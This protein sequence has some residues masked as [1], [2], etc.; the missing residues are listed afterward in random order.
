[1]C[2]EVPLV[3]LG[4][5]FTIAAYAV[6]RAAR[7][8][9]TELIAWLGGQESASG[10]NVWR[11]SNGGATFPPTD[12]PMVDYSNWASG[13]TTSTAAQRCAAI[14]AIHGKWL[15]MDC[16][17]H[18]IYLV[19][20]QIAP[21]PVPPPSPP[22]TPPAVVALVVAGAQELSGTLLVVLVLSIGGPLS[23]M[24]VL[25]VRRLVRRRRAALTEAGAGGEIQ[26]GDESQGVVG[27]SV[28]RDSSGPSGTP[29]A[30]PGRK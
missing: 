8:Q 14:D 6:L 19:C 30:A 23:I 26:D 16:G 12:G 28:T 4:S 25:L 7:E 15:A 20:Q 27:T 10:S 29:A 11:W 5:K 24:G 22:F 2:F 21:P 13:M 9:G 1:M 17:Q 18:L 3:D